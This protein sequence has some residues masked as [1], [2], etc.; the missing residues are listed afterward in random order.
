MTRGFLKKYKKY[1]IIT[2]LLEILTIFLPYIVT[3]ISLKK[4][5]LKLYSYEKSGK[6]VIINTN[7]INTK[8]D[9][10]EFIPCVLYSILPID[11]E[12][13]ALKAEI[14][15][16]RTYIF[17]KMGNNNSINVSELKLP[18]TLFNQLEEKWGKDYEYNY[19][20]TMKLINKTNGLIIT[21]E[22][23]PIYP[24]YHELSE[25]KTADGEFPYL[26]SVDSAGDIQ[27]EDYLGIIYYTKEDMINKLKENFGLDIKPEELLSKIVINKFEGN[28]YVSTVSVGDKTIPGEDFTT[29]FQLASNSFTI[30]EFSEGIKIVCK[31]KGSGKGLSLYGA[32]NLALEG[33]SYE[34]II[35]YYFTGVNCEKKF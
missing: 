12:E 32:K 16:I 22:G 26:K 7:G 6:T 27:A 18:Y 2:F 23:N 30:E 24:Y 34:E 9:V 8:M 21:Y 11:Y 33:K 10:E 17:Y 13:E 3:S 14:L 29:A 5:E 31:G 15:I 35:K 1:I 19:N 28:N 25:G 4:T 20:Y